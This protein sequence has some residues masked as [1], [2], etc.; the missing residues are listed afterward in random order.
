MASG[1]VLMNR[2]GIMNQRGDAFDSLDAEEGDRVPCIS[3]QTDG[4]RDFLRVA[5]EPVA[6]FPDCES[7]NGKVLRFRGAA[8]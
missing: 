3:P 7:R 4:A 1:I 5:A 8:G 6:R 2:N